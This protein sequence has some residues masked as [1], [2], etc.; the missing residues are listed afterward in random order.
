MDRFIGHCCQLVAYIR[1]SVRP[2]VPWAFNG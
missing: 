2:S 1:P